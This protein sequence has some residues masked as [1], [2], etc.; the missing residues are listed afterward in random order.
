MGGNAVRNTYSGLAALAFAAWLG[1]LSL[2]VAQQSK[3]PVKRPP[4]C[5][6]ISTQATCAARTDCEWVPAVA[7][8]DGKQKRK[9]FC[10][11]KPKTPAK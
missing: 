4:A 7:D 9:A 5:N 10:K 3:E 1:S 8:K 2:A 6:A 11:S